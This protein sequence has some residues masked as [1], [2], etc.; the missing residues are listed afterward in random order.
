MT[1]NEVLGR[2]FSSF[3]ARLSQVKHDQCSR[4]GSRRIQYVHTQRKDPGPPLPLSACLNCPPERLS[5]W[6]GGEG[7]TL[8]LCPGTSRVLIHTDV[9]LSVQYIYT[10]LSGAGRSLPQRCYSNHWIESCCSNFGEH[11]RLAEVEMRR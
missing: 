8:K 3:F 9:C 4:E 6:R 11:D 10:L 7:K 1:S 5:V 2:G